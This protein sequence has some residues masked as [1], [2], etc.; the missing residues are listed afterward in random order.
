MSKETY[1]S[2][3]IRI[4]SFTEESILAEKMNRVST[5]RQRAIVTQVTS[6]NDEDKL[7]EVLAM[8]SHIYRW[9]P[10]RL[11]TDAARSQRSPGRSNADWPSWGVKATCRSATTRL[12]ARFFPF[13]RSSRLLS[14]D[15]YGN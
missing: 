2:L 7:T 8:Q 6:T 14:F 9:Y 15:L 3:V 1:S 4:S 10:P 13:A 11:A 5:L 12:A